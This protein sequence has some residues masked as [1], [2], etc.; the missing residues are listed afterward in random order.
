MRY[1]A[2]LRGCAALFLAGCTDT[3][4]V[5]TEV[6]STPALLT[7]A[8]LRVVTD[9]PVPRITPDNPSR[10]A[11][12]TEPSP[13]VA[14][15]LSTALGLTAQATVPSGVTAGGSV[16]NQ[17]TEQATE[18]GVRIPPVS[19]LRDG[20]Y[21]LCEAWTNG[22][23]GDAAYAL[24]LS[25]Y[26]ELLVSLILADDVTAAARAQPAKLTSSLTPGIDGTGSSD[27]NGGATKPATTASATGAAA[28]PA[29]G[30][31]SAAQ[32]VLAAASQPAQPTTGAPAATA[33]KS[34]TTKP[35]TSPTPSTTAGSG[36]TPATPTPGGTNGSTTSSD[37]TAAA[38]QVLEQMQA[39]YLTLSGAG[40]LIVAC[41]AAND[42][43]TPGWVPNKVLTPELCQ[44]FLTG[45]M[46][47][48]K[49]ATANKT[50]AK[51]PTSTATPTTKT[52]PTP[53]AATTP[54]STAA[55][56]P[57]PVASIATARH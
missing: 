23:I 9:R 57:T 33:S 26:G 49:D 22:A 29:D 19:A 6:G 42:E 27:G 52:A 21:R 2:L 40:P 36:T 46:D 37:T 43:T 56:T 44:R 8:D 3:Y 24:S 11:V 35:A 38:A 1:A 7:T 16:D 34:T 30:T 5:N 45:Y 25:R 4:H 13:D 54:A 39:N 20:T 47:T 48:L 31:A 50:Q 15:A 55:S 28:T 53:A 32:L 51:V 18:L 14:K 10:R 12:C 41:I 17:T